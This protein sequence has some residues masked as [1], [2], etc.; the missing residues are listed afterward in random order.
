MPIK[1]GVPKQSVV[2]NKSPICYSFTNATG[3]VH[4]SPSDVKPVAVTDPHGP[5]ESLKNDTGMAIKFEL[6]DIHFIWL[7]TSTRIESL[8]REVL[9][10]KNVLEA[11]D[12]ARW[13]RNSGVLKLLLQNPSD[14]PLRVDGKALDKKIGDLLF[15]CGEKFRG[16]KITVTYQPSDIDE[17]NRKMDLLASHIARFAPS[18]TV[19]TEAPEC[20]ALR[21]IQGGR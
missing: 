18:P 21:V 9:E 1:T 16:G 7:H 12:F 5:P 17:I 11:A 15:E 6:A 19:A 8:Y 14:G 2:D 4:E 13:L 20:P 3:S 10:G